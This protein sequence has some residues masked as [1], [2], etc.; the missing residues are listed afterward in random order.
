MR[1][2][3][4][5]IFLLAVLFAQIV[6][7]EV[8]FNPKTVIHKSVDADGHVIFSKSGFADSSQRKP[9]VVETVKPVPP[10]PTA[11]KVD[12]YYASWD[13]YS[14]KAIIFFR[15]NHIVV[16]AYDIDLDA[17]AAARKKKIDPAFVGMP[18]VV[19]NGIVIRGVDEKKYQEALD[20]IPK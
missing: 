17:E 6:Q 10:K 18:L 3:Q 13:P 20:T 12:V 5:I 19:I 1:V 2:N 14:N 7:A 4:T 9:K 11:P 16:N 8:S 15:D